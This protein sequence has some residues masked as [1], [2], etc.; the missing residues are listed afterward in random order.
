MPDQLNSLSLRNDQIRNSRD[1]MVLNNERESESSLARLRGSLFCKLRLCENST[2]W[3]YLRNIHHVFPVMF[4]ERKGQ[5]LV[6]S[7]RDGYARAPYARSGRYGCE[8][9]HTRSE[10][11]CSF[12]R[13]SIKALALEC[14]VT[15]ELYRTYVQ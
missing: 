11:L 10:L 13:V 14:Q 8:C 3:H 15:F 1:T 9:S 4:C 6:T 12:P 2:V 7:T 5:K